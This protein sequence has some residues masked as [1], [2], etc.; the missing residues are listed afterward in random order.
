MT[1]QPRR[2][3]V[4]ITWTRRPLFS[5]S[6]AESASAL[7]KVLGQRRHLPSQH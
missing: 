6:H 5:G 2:A 4:S 3:R 7:C 1:M